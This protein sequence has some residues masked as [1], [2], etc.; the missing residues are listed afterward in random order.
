MLRI[1]KKDPHSSGHLASA[2]LDDDAI[3]PGVHG[4]VARRS[5]LCPTLRCFIQVYMLG[6][7]IFAPSLQALSVFNIMMPSAFVNDSRPNNLVSE[8]D[9][10]PRRPWPQPD[11]WRARLDYLAWPHIVLWDSVGELLD[12]LV[13]TDLVAL[14]ANMRA[15]ARERLAE[16]RRMWRALLP[17]AILQ[18]T[19]AT[20]TAPSGSYDSVVERRYPRLKPWLT[21]QH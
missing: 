11:E 18:P 4:P 21:P 8:H 3:H 5:G 2:L 15:H 6:L 17:D 13:A 14:S 16:S 19:H 12:K 7:P 10:K 9:D 20:S 1:R